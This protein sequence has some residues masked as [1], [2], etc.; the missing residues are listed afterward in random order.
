MPNQ[1]HSEA[2]THRENAA[3]AHQ[4]AAEHHGKNDPWASKHSEEAHGHS[5]KALSLQGRSR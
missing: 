2:A 1:A 5:T 3:K 4:T